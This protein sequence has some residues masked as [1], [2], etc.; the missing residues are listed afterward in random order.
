MKHPGVSLAVL[1][2]LTLVASGASA[3]EP[4]DGLHQVGDHW[5][6]CNP[7][8]GYEPGVEIHAIERGDTLWDLAAHFYGDSYLWPQLW[9]RNQYIRDAHWIYPGDPLV[10]GFEVTPLETLAELQEAVVPDDEGDGF[11]RSVGAPRPLGSE[12]DLY[13]SGYIADTAR[14]FPRR[15]IG[16]EY[17]NLGPTLTS[18]SKS[19]AGRKRM[20]RNLFALMM[21]LLMRNWWN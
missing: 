13:C 2:A 3:H 6:A 18:A 20:L 4:P 8:T 7:P 15:V 9:E 11:D 10:V 16:S 17:Q 5:T 12:S 19:R 1:V 14:T 21:E